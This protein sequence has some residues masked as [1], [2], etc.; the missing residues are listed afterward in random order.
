MKLLSHLDLAQVI[1]A[2][3]ANKTNLQN[4]FMTTY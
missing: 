1:R 2:R 3:R 4:K